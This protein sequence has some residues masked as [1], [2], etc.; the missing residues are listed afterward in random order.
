MHVVS[1]YL[2]S[3]SL[4]LV[5]FSLPDQNAADNGGLRSQIP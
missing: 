1:K 2:T 3:H 4:Y 5:I